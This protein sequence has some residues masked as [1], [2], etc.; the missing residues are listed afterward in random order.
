MYWDEGNRK[1]GK[2]VGMSRP[3][4]L[5]VSPSSCPLPSALPFTLPASSP[6]LLLAKMSK[7]VKA[8]HDSWD[9]LGGTR[10]LSLPGIEMIIFSCSFAG[11]NRKHLTCAQE[12][13]TEAYFKFRNKTIPMTLTVKEWKQQPFLAGICI[14][15]QD[16]LKITGMSEFWVEFSKGILASLC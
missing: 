14:Q 4:P 13:C 15:Q 2:E 10:I 7:I 16:A 3:S 11:E 6:P 12:R 8:H 1:K 9:N 5:P